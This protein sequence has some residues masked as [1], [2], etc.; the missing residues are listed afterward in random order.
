MPAPVEAIRV[1]RTWVGAP[2][3]TLANPT[4][5]LLVLALALLAIGDAGYLAW[6]WPA[7]ATIGVN[8]TALYIV[9]TP[10][11]EAMHGIAHE[12]AG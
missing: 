2:A 12:S 1:D 8:A 5:H 7:W 9:F 4:V 11:H 6:G 3:G 10:L